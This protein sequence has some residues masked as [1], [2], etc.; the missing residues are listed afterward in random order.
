MEMGTL[1]CGKELLIS[2]GWYLQRGG[3]LK[4]KN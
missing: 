2:R 1:C 3:V 4:R